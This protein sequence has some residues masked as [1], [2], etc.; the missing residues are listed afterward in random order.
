MINL[1]NKNYSNNKFASRYS[2]Y[3]CIE[4]TEN[5][6]DLIEWVWV[7]C[8]TCFPLNKNIYEKIKKIKKKICIV[9]PELQGQ[10]EKIFEYRQQ[11]IDNDIIPNAICCK[12]CNIF[13]WL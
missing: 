12:E 4:Y 9:S 6:K 11:L 5:I 2:E 8:F 7:D 1:L 3:E 13:E 10:P